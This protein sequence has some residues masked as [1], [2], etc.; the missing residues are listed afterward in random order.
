MKKVLVLIASGVILVGSI[1]AFGPA[2]RGYVP[3]LQPAQQQVSTQANTQTQ[4]Q[5]QQFK[6]STR[7][8]RNLPQDATLGALQTFK[9]TIKEV[10]F[11]TIKGF[12]LKVQVGNDVY[13][14]HAGPIF[15]A[16]SLKAGDSIEI[17]G[18][19]LTTSSEKYIVAEKVTV[20]GK[21]INID[22][23]KPGR[24]APNRANNTNRVPARG[25]QRSP[26]M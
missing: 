16:A 7:L 21:T 26:R 23:V 9:G 1:F 6:T 20:G 13:D 25:M 18:R 10:S 24:K 4:A 5:V 15:R 19:L 3:V 17:S 12:I 8:Y 11:D 14:V 2:N 22:D